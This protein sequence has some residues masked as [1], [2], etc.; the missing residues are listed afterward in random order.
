MTGVYKTRILAYEDEAD[1]Y[2]RGAVAREVFREMPRAPRVTQLAEVQGR[3]LEQVPFPFIREG[4]FAGIVFRKLKVH[5]GISDSEEWRTAALFPELADPEALKALPREK[6]YD[7]WLSGGDLAFPGPVNPVR[8]ENSW[9]G[10]YAIGHPQ[11]TQNGHTM[12]DHGIVL[13][14]GLGSIQDRLIKRVEER[15]AS[16]DP[17]AV[18]QFSAMLR[19]VGGLITHIERAAALY[20]SEAAKEE[21][22]LLKGRLAETGRICR[23]IAKETPSTLAEA[24]QLLFF[25]YTA[26]RVANRGD[27]SSFGRVDRLLAP[28]IPEKATEETA[29]LIRQF[30]LKLFGNQESHNMTL[31]GLTP[32]G[33]DGTNLLSRL[34]LE[35]MIEN[36]VASDI[37]VRTHK[38]TPADF[39]DLIA[40][41]ATRDLGRP[42]VY[43][44]ET[45]IAGLVKLGVKEEDA[46][47]YALLGCSEV[48][49]PGR[50]TGRTMGFNLNTMK[51]L[52]LVLNGGRCLVSGDPVLGNIPRDYESFDAF[53][54]RYRRE[55][56]RIIGIGIEI[57]RE[58]ERT[59]SFHQPRPWLTVLTRGGLDDGRDKTA[60]VPRYDL[61]GVTLSA[62]ADT[63][64]S[65]Y[66]V[67]HLVY[68]TGRLT[69]EELRDVLRNNWEGREDLRSYC[70]NGL[71][72]FGSDHEEINALMRE[73]SAFFARSFEGKP[74]FFG[75][76]FMPMIF[77]L[78]ILSHNHNELTGA[79]P[80]GRLA[81][82]ALASTLQPSAEGM[83]GGPTEL[84]MSLTEVEGSRFPGGISNVQDFLPG[85]VSGEEGR[86]RLI[87]LYKGYFA[88]GGLELG[89][90]FLTVEKLREAQ[91]YPEKYPYLMVRLFG[92]SARFVNLSRELQESVIRRVGAAA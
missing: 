44:D 31:G 53:K 7:F 24:L 40:R 70:L 73:E 47:D 30:L 87:S 25:S 10:R 34:F 6:G 85:F 35:A 62:L 23:K 14:L 45:E 49:I 37:T 78:H 9:I 83:R 50:S 17:A 42:N 13:S 18:I 26:D 36:G 12:A 77:G 58:D 54:E 56:A 8:R 69:L 81:G 64:N 5:G 48:M 91:E 2:F 90:N 33:K 22:P 76:A 66:A 80:S 57:I 4:F 63:V 11:G 16:D 15:K 38:G 79:T 28:F 84:L 39:W 55:V 59:E 46:R 71:P 20:E 32:N 72:R 82:T 60:G 86:K 1:P 43:S 89:V 27:A 68:D 52:E 92:M 29:D 74:T 65:L 61:V 51:I 75:G 41:A 67:K 3:Y 88:R 21:D 19:I